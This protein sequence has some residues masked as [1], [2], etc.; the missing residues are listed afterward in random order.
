MLAGAGL[1]AAT[2]L[3]ASL[4][5]YK[6]S[7]QNAETL[8]V[9]SEM[10]LYSGQLVAEEVRRNGMLAVERKVGEFAASGVDVGN[11][12]PIHVAAGLF[13]RAELAAKTEEMNAMYRS[14]NLS[15]KASQVKELGTMGLYGGLLGA[16]GTGLHGY[17]EF[18]NK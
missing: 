13:A 2:Q 17:G 16:A 10:E 3:Y 11:G 5:G 12:S 6:V 18:A 8:R 4:Q 7:L 9:Q 14:R 1:S 15:D